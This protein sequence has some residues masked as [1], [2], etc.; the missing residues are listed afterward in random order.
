MVSGKAI[1]HRPCLRKSKA[2]L[3]I[4]KHMRAAVCLPPLMHISV[5]DKAVK[6]VR[7]L[8]ED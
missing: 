3:Q 2:A 5:V 4:Q 7:I 1:P 6:K 8:C